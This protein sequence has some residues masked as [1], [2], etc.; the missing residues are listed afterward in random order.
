[1]EPAGLSY[2]ARC[3]LRR[4]GRCC[5]QCLHASG[6][7]WRGEKTG[8]RSQDGS[9]R[10]NG[11]LRVENSQNL[12]VREERLTLAVCGGY[13]EVPA[14][15][16]TTPL[17]WLRKYWLHVETASGG[18]CSRWGLPLSGTVTHH[19]CQTPSPL[20]SSTTFMLGRKTLITCSP[21]NNIDKTARLLA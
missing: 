14:F 21:G 8:L 11:R 2:K 10:R 9:S 19:L 6:R 1:M 4:F 20:Y 13:M 16:P 15:T 18:P 5:V 3:V 12:N 17:R 7:V